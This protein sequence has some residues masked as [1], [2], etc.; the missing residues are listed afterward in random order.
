M[1]SADDYNQKSR[2]TLEF[3]VTGVCEERRPVSV[4]GGACDSRWR[5]KGP[6]RNLALESHDANVNLECLVPCCKVRLEYSM[7][8][9]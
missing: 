8:A 1:T 9:L 4:G 6:V 5:A 2:Q 7:L 3:E